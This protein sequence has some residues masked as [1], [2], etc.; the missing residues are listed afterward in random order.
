MSIFAAITGSY[1]ISF[2]VIPAG[3]QSEDLHREQP[4]PSD[5]VIFTCTR[6]ESSVATLLW[7]VGGEPSSSLYRFEIP[8]DIG[9]PNASKTF[10]PGFTGVL[11]NETTS[12]LYTDLRIPSTN[13][14][15][16]NSMYCGQIGGPISYPSKPVLI[17]GM[18]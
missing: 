8:R 1:N 12:L 18:R 9:T 11:V 3:L 16:K 14:I 4:C 17:K 15:N 10:L 13:I 2:E 7:V 5:V 6:S